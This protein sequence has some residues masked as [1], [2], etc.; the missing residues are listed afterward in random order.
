[1]LKIL[2][3]FMKI[4]FRVLILKE[5]EA[6]IT[7]RISLRNLYLIFSKKLLHKHGRSSLKVKARLGHGS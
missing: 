2:C 3:S 7:S 1:M 4:N 6:Y 5:I